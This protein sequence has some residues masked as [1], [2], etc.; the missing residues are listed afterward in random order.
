MNAPVL[1]V[2]DLHV[3]F[4][5]AREPVHAVRGVGFTLDAGTVMG[6]GP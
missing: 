2:D 5:S 6:V 3:R 4:G 1:E